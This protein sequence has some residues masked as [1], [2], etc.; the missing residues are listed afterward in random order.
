VK[1]IG[2][3]ISTQTTPKTPAATG[4]FD[5]DNVRLTVIPEPA[6]ASMLVLAGAIALGARRRQQ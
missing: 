2:I 5:F 3:R 4:Q 6:S 1:H